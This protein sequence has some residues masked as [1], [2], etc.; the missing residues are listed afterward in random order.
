MIFTEIDH[1]FAD[2][3]KKKKWIFNWP[4]SPFKAYVQT[5]PPTPLIEKIVPIKLDF[6]IEQAE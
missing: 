3:K 2:L 1:E 4:K 5:V 6:D